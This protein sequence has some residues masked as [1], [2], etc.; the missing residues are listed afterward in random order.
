MER[1]DRRTALR[2]LTGA[3]TALA[4]PTP[5]SQGSEF[6]SSGTFSS[7]ESATSLPRDILT[8]EELTERGITVWN[9]EDVKLHLRRRAIEEEPLFQQPLRDSL[10]GFDIVL[11]D[12]AAVKSYYLTEEQKA[13]IPDVVSLLEPQEQA[14]RTARLNYYLNNQGPKQKEYKQRLAT[15]EQHI[16]ERRWDAHVATVERQALRERFR[17]FLYEPTL[18]DLNRGGSQTIIIE[19]EGRRRALIAMRDPDAVTFFSGTVS[20]READDQISRALKEDQ[21]YPDSRYYRDS[22]ERRKITAMPPGLALRRMIAEISNPADPEGR[23]ISQLTA[24][25]RAYIRNQDD[26]LYYYAFETPL[27]MVTT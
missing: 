21:S 24:A 16:S 9:L 13:A 5:Q 26:S 1:I 10:V 19:S 3:V 6:C 8:R 23:V 22:L 14:S 18:E 12:G 7:S 4:L 2:Q 20:I 17:P 27:F 15:L 25:E 11:I